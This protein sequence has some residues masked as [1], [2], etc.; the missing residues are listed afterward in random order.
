M[1]VKNFLQGV[2]SENGFYCVFAA[3]KETETKVTKFYETI[4][5]VERAAMKFDSSGMDTYFALA[6]FQEPTNRKHDNAYEFKSLFLDLDVGPSK[7]YATQQEAVSDLRKF[8]KQLSLPKPL[9]V[10]SGRGV[11]VYWPLTEAVSVDTWLDAA[12]RLKR[13]CS[14]NGFRAD[15]AVT[16]DRSRILRVPHTHNYKEGTPLPTEFLGVEMPQPVVLSEF[17]QKLGIVMPVTKIDLGTD[18]LYEAYAENSENVFKTIV[19]KTFAGRGCKQIEFIATKQAEVSEPLW[20]AGLSIAKFCVDADKAAEKISNRHPDYNEAEMRKKLDEIKGPYTCV[21]FD[22]LNEGICRDCPLWG[23]IKS[24]IVLGKR[25]R[26]SEGVVSVSAPVQGKKTQK[27]FDIPEYPKP[28]FRGVRGGVFLRGSNAEG[29]ITEDLIYHHDIYITRRLHDE[30]LGETLVFRLH[31]PKDGVRQFSVPLKHVTSK[32]EFRKSMAHEGVTAWG[33]SLDKLMVYTTRWVDELQRTSTADEAHRQFGWVDDDMDAFVLG[34]KLIEASDVTYNPPSSKTAGLMDTFEPKGTKESSLEVFDF[35][36]RDGFELHQYVVGVGF[37][38]PLMALTGLNSMAVH[39][40]GGTGVG[41]TTA[42]MAA[43]SIWGDPE[44]LMLQKD[45]THNSRMNRGEIMHSLPLVSDEM[46]NVTSREMS[47]YVY[48]VSGGRQKNRLSSNGNVERIRGKPWKLLA[49]SSG[50]TSAWEIL[51]RDKATPKA[52]MQRLFEIKVTKMI[53][54]IGNNS[55]T[56]DLLE[57]VKANYGHVGVEYIQWIINNREEARAIVKRAKARLDTAA[58]LGPENRFWSNGNAVVLAGLIIAKQLGFIKYDI[59][60]V[61]KWI[62]AELI[63]RNSFVNE[64]GASVSETLNNYLSENYNNLLKI[65]STEDLRGRNDNGLDQLVPISASPRGQL[66]A[67]FEPDTKL[68]FLRIKP[69]KD[70]CV[71]Q[72][73]NYASVVDDLKEKMGAKR[74][75]KRLTKGTDLNMP[76]QDVLELKFAEFDE[77]EDGSKGNEA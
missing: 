4:E 18:A 22:E 27:E 14:E 33:K 1:E 17:V 41:K 25:I 19:E 40:Y 46:T 28:Y 42:Q 48:Q 50:N 73:I 52:E 23:E 70:W 2:L 11:H 47:E 53:H 29:D 13:A 15:P 20:R 31:L 64:I 62:V 77:G 21:R 49:L 65:E 43:M 56:A 55:D 10:N 38:S 36:N 39:L 8:C 37:G 67:R 30:E 72:Q 61:Y 66:V 74:T 51:S 24:P 45:D 12:E 6:T 57:K 68:L 71:D 59:A 58:K 9:M 3:H 44:L 34:E 69:F 75:K 5:E 32:E 16:A 54:S 63:R 76:P 7:E 26:E 60:K 35:Y